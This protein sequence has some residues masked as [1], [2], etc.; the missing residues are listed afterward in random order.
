MATCS[1]QRGAAPR[2]VIT[3]RVR[4]QDELQCCLTATGS[5]RTVNPTGPPH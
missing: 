3:T 2:A 5:G 4:A 1:R